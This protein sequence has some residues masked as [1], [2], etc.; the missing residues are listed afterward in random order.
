[1]KSEELLTYLFRGV[2]VFAILLALYIAVYPAV[3]PVVY[4]TV[5]NTGYPSSYDEPQYVPDVL[6]I[7]NECRPGFTR[8]GNMCI[9]QCYEHPSLANLYRN[10]ESRPNN[11]IAQLGVDDKWE[12]V[13]SAVD[14][15]YMCPPGYSKGSY[16]E[17]N[18]K[19]SCVEDCPDGMANNSLAETCYRG[20]LTCS[21]SDSVEK[22]QLTE[23]SPGYTRKTNMVGQV[24]CVKDGMG[25]PAGMENNS[26][27]LGCWKTKIDATIS[28]I[29]DMY[30]LQNS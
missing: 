29:E 15:C 5:Y 7:P 13:S 6:N 26:E 4:P 25:C 22:C 9:K 8:Q 28:N 1:M 10:P 18:K 2:L 30:M 27:Y 23:C 19:M 21:P 24:I 17:I 3:Y 20:Y 12:N 16:D 11:L 14:Y